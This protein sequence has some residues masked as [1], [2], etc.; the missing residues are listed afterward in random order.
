MVGFV[1]YFRKK[2]KALQDN[3]YVMQKFGGLIAIYVTLD[4]PEGSNNYFLDPQVLQNLADFE[5]KLKEDPDIAYI[6]S[7]AS[8]LKL[9]NLTMNGDFTIPEKRPLIL[10]LS[11]YFKS[12][13]STGSGRTILST[14]VNLEF[15][16]LTLAMRIYD[17]QNVTFLF[18]DKLKDLEGRNLEKIDKNFAG[19]PKPVLW[20]GALVSLSEVRPPD[21]DSDAD[22]DYAQHRPHDTAGHPLR[23]GDHLVYQRGHRGGDR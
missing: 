14:L 23:C 19:K 8:Y 7:F 9:M 10:L 16:R 18:E 2:P 11:R 12:I 21:P 13:F 17:S 22:R 1:S 4:A 3:L 5:E 6:A 15:N 20:G